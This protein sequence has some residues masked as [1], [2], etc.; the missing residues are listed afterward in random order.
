MHK[1]AAGSQ[2]AVVTHAQ[3]CFE[4]RE[5]F[6][7]CW[8]APF[9]N[10]S[11]PDARRMSLQMSLQTQQVNS[12]I[13]SCHLPRRNAARTVRACR[14]PL[15]S[16]TQPTCCPL[17]AGS[18][19]QE[20]LPLIT[21]YFRPKRDRS[22]PELLDT[23]S[24]PSPVATTPPTAHSPAPSPAPRPSPA[25]VT[26]LAAT[27]APPTTLNTGPTP[28]ASAACLYTFPRSPASGSGRRWRITTLLV[29]RKFVASSQCLDGLPASLQPEPDNPMDKHA[30]HVRPHQT[31]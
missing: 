15:A 17:P 10:A 21:Q 13:Q 5:R 12:A 8:G 23:T 26:A 28:A 16:Q 25:S 27:P 20:S 9:C 24:L 6:K 11:A 22:I 2:L 18:P 14:A 4:G 29:G 3:S 7:R 31:A 1:T 30:L 19:R